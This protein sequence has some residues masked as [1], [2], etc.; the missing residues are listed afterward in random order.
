MLLYIK[1]WLS[2]R[3]LAFLCLDFTLKLKR[4]ISYLLLSILSLLSR[5]SLVS[6]FMAVIAPLS[7]NL[8]STSL[9]Y[10][11]AS[12]TSRSQLSAY[13][14]RFLKPHKSRSAYCSIISY[15]YCFARQRWSLFADVFPLPP[16]SPGRRCRPPLR[17]RLY[18]SYILS[19]AWAAT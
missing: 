3:R 19:L 9:S 4:N 12:M 7:P 11:S 15:R 1:C 8:P 16:A 17:Y 6:S 18:M 14:S 13:H 2:E 5:V 10:L